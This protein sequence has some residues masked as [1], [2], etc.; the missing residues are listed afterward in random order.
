MVVTT[1]VVSAPVSV[2]VSVRRE[3]RTTVTV[4][5]GPASLIVR[6]MV[7]PATFTVD[8]GTV[9]VNGHSM[10]EG[11]TVTVSIDAPAGLLVT[12]GGAIEIVVTTADVVGAAAASVKAASSQ[13]FCPGGEAG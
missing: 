9:A 6:V 12:T 7:C 5:G 3:A 10:P 2:K 4:V 13:G 1:A 11:P 8:V